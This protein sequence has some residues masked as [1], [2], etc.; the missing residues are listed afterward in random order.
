MSDDA[1]VQIVRDAYEAWNRD[2]PHGTRPVGG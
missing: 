1:A 2:G